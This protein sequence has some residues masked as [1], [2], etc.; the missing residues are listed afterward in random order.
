[1]IGSQ[2]SHESCGM[3]GFIMTQGSSISSVRIKLEKWRKNA[4]QLF[5]HHRTK[6][7]KILEIGLCFAAYFCFQKRLFVSPKLWTLCKQGFIFLCCQQRRYKSCGLCAGSASKP[8]TSRK[9][10]ST[11]CSIV[12][13][14]LGL[15]LYIHTYFRHCTHDLYLYLYLYILYLYV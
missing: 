5:S 15:C 4:T 6:L 8:E 12:L 7:F 2:W 14:T 10:E 9:A 11:L 3:I 13:W 1:M